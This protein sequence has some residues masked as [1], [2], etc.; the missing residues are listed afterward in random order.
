MSRNALPQPETSVVREGEVSTNVDRLEEVKEQLRP[1]RPVSEVGPKA[2]ATVNIH[3]DVAEAI[4]TLAEC[5]APTE[6]SKHR[7]LVGVSSEFST[8]IL[9]RSKINQTV[10]ADF[11]GDDGH[12]FTI[13]SRRDD[14]DRIEVKG[15]KEWSDPERTI[16]ADKVAKADRYVLCRTRQPTQ[17]VEVVGSASRL[18]VEY[19]GR[20]WGRDGYTLTPEYLSPVGP[21]RITAKETKQL[22]EELYQE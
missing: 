18:Q 19:L 16:E 17:R 12:D 8:A 3:P 11:E 6:D 2:H 20:M 14:P 10:Y 4:E 13:P 7:H 15:T 9:F 1:A 5:R 21:E 22:A